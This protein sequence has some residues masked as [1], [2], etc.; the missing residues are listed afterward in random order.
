MADAQLT[1][2]LAG[3]QHALQFV[4]EAPRVHQVGGKLFV[5]QFLLGNGFCGLGEF[6]TQDTQFLVMLRSGRAK[7]AGDVIIGFFRLSQR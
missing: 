4:L 7:L 3:G 6:E 5:D 2:F 1:V